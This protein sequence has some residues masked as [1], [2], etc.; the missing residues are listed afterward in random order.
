MAKE[1]YTK[2]YMEDN[3]VSIP[4]R[5]SFTDLTGNTYGKIRVIAWGG[6]RQNKKRNQWWCKCSCGDTDYFLVDANSLKKNLTT[7]C[8]CNYKSNGTDRFTKQDFEEKLDKRYEVLHYS[9]M[10]RKCT[11]QC[12]TCGDKED[13]LTGYSV[14]QRGLW[15]S[16]K[17]GNKV[18]EKR[19]KIIQWISSFDYKLLPDLEVTTS[20][21]LIDIQCIHC[22]NIKR[23]VVFHAISHK[24]IC[25]SSTLRVEQPSGVYLLQDKLNLSY[26]KIGKAYNP[27]TRVKQIQKSVDKSEYNHKWFIKGIKWFATEYVAYSVE[28]LYHHFFKDKTLYGYKNTKNRDVVEFDG[29]GETFILC[30]EDFENFNRDNKDLLNYLE[31]NKPE[32]IIKRPFLPST[33]VLLSKNNVDGVFI[34]NKKYL[35]GKLGYE[36]TLSNIAVIAEM[37]GIKDIAQQLKNKNKTLDIYGVPYLSYSDFYEQHLH[38]KH[39]DVDLSL[40]L[41]RARS[42]KIDAYDSLIQPRKKVKRAT[43][44]DLKGNVISFRDA[45]RQ[46]KPLCSYATMVNLLKKGVPLEEVL[47]YIPDNRF[48]PIYLYK[49]RYYS[50]RGLYDVLNCT[51]KRHTFTQRVS[52]GW[53]AEIASF[54]PEDNNRPYRILSKDIYKYYPNYPF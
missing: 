19:D 33:H 48:T 32:I 4:V 30:K 53:S 11:V 40:F 24:C 29:A 44:K 5:S 42:K 34:P 41:D 52:N 36:N 14:R 21:K 9:G 46:Y 31:V 47:E 51:I 12:F 23:G 49:G 2:T 27:Y 15:C 6:M 16:C 10:D 17:G 26:F 13:Q 28:H 25:L 1:F 38:F 43:T 45:Y 3:T 20:S 8:G 50:G 18:N 39:E 7:S 54:V 37:R 22:G 35:L